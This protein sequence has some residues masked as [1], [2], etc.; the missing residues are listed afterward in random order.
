MDIKIF[1]SE[2]VIV[3]CKNVFSK[4]VN[5]DNLKSASTDHG[6]ILSWLFVIFPLF[7]QLLYILN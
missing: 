7:E 4:K 5:S 1:K 6:Q 2:C 3:I